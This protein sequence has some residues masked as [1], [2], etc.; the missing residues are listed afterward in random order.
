[1]REREGGGMMGKTILLI[2]LKERSRVVEQAIR[3]RTR[4]IGRILQSRTVLET[5]TSV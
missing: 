2:K 1:M 4:A 3:L 5:K